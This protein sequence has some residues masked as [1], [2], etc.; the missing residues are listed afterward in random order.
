MNLQESVNRTNLVHEYLPDLSKD[1]WKVTA[2]GDCEDY[3][4]EVIWEYSNRSFFPFVW[5]ILFGGFSF[6][7]VGVGP[8]T[9]AAGK[10]LNNGHFVVEDKDSDLFFDNNFR[11]LVLKEDMEEAGYNFKYRFYKVKV[12]WRLLLGLKG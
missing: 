1:V 3:G 6:W 5:N 11:N 12:L 4:F 2:S 8:D 10:T 9:N 7:Y